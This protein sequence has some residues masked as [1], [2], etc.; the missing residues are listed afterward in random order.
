[1]Q[2]NKLKD[3]IGFVTRIANDYVY[4]CLVIGNNYT[5]VSKYSVAFLFFINNRYLFRRITVFSAIAVYSRIFR[6]VAQ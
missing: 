6:I 3:I 1:M 2:F 5:R 4:I